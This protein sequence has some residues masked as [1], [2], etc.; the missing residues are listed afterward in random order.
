MSLTRKERLERILSVRGADITDSSE[1][2]LLRRALEVAES[3]RYYDTH[4]DSDGYFRELLPELEFVLANG[5][6][7]ESDGRMEPAQALLYTFI[8]NLHGILETFNRRWDGLP[9]W[10]IDEVGGVPDLPLIPALLWVA[11][12]K[13]TR[14]EVEINRATGFVLQPSGVVLHPEERVSLENATIERIVSVHYGHEE[15]LYPASA[16]GCVTSVEVRELPDGGE[17]LLFAGKQHLN[18]SHSPGF[19]ISSPAL[20]LHEGRRSVCMRLETETHALTGFT[21]I[22]REHLSERDIFR[23]LENIFYAEISTEAEWL[24]IKDIRTVAEED[25]PDNLTLRFILPEEFPATAACTE[26]LHGITSLFPALKVRLNTEAWLYPYTWI[27]NFVLKRIVIDIDVQGCSSLMVYNDLGRVDSSK[28]FLPFG[29]DS[30]RGAWFVLGSHEMAI[31]NTESFDLRIDW[32]GLPEVSLNDHYSG[33]RCN[34]DNR[35]FLLDVQYLRDYGWHDITSRFLFATDPSAPDNGPLKESPLAPQSILK[36]IST[37]HMTAVRDEDYDY[38]IRSKTGFVRFR[39]AAPEIGLGEVRYRSLF[40]EQMLQALKK[41]KNIK[42]LN[43]PITPSVERIT[44]DYRA[45]DRIEPRDGSTG[46]DSGFW[47]IHPL[48][49]RKVYPGDDCRLVPLVS[50]LDGDAHLL[51]SISGIRGGEYLRLWFDFAEVEREINCCPAI[52]W[53]WGDGYRWQPLPDHVILCDTTDNFAGAGMIGFDIPE[54]VPKGTLWFR[55]TIISGIRHVPILRRIVPNAVRLITDKDFSC[56]VDFT[57]KLEKPIPG[58]VGV[59]CLS[60]V[61][62]NRGQETA[63]EKLARFSEH[64]TH[65]GRAVTARD[66][67]RLVLQE[68]P[69]IAYAECFPCLD[70]KGSRQGVVTVLVIPSGR[71]RPRMTGKQIL[72]IEKYLTRCASPAVAQ[73]DVINPLYEEVMIKGIGE[74]RTGYSTGHCRARLKEL[75]DMLIAPWQHPG[76]TPSPGPLRWDDIAAAIRSEPYVERL[77]KMSIIRLERRRSTSYRIEESDAPGGV[78]FPSE[79]YA[80]FV[81][82]REHLFPVGDELPFGVGEMAIGQHLIIND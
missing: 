56:P 10:Y 74:F 32:S 82:A 26:D 67:E 22:T 15:N 76:E 53:S 6:L 45:S 12:K 68:F 37:E 71:D 70:T 51:F 46:S 49:I 65:H 25:N 21:E 3:L 81:P 2:S 29:T 79:P 43:P 44:A 23:L 73:V 77:D 18:N 69:E 19:I 31:K 72:S 55:A 62:G 13:G 50:S 7:P 40:P 20:L 54:L 33:Y 78:L 5:H 30:E 35:S 11:P 80:I 17:G 63:V 38:T 57:V 1:L 60:S 8:H 27:R 28:P 75:C 47:H 14:E 42:A 4:G 34:I 9:Q 24:P 58:I 41:K 52:R 59:D 61:S 66:Y 64:I 16:L 48:G 39:L 36:N